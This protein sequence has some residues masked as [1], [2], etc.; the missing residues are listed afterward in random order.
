MAL[1]TKDKRGALL[2]LLPFPNNDIDENDRR[3]FL[4]LWRTIDLTGPT[5]VID[6]IP[7]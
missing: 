2:D 5:Y 1:D 4:G 7:K 6:A 3:Q